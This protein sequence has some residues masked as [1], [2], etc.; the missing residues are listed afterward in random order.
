LWFPAGGIL[1]QRK[2]SQVADQYP[3]GATTAAGISIPLN[4]FGSSCKN[5]AQRKPWPAESPVL[6][7]QIFKAHPK[8]NECYIGHRSAN[9]FSYA[10]VA[11][12]GDRHEQTVGKNGAQCAFSCR[13]PDPPGSACIPYQH[14]QVNQRCV[15]NSV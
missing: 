5:I 3:K 1:K 14:A 11:Q 13:I 12:P 9:I 15:M 7:V 6:Q 10:E 8:S 4:P 2:G